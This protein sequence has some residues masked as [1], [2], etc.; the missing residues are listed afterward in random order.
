MVVSLFGGGSAVSILGMQMSSGFFASLA[1]APIAGA[2]T[3]A[4]TVTTEAGKAINWV[5]MIMYT[6]GT[7]F[8][9]NLML[10]WIRGDR[11]GWK[12]RVKI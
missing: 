10:V 7:M 11:T 2:I 12:W 5:P 9:G 4:N 8:V 6:G 1:G 3:D